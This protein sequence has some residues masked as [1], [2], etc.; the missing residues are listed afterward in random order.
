MHLG[1]DPGF[2][3]PEGHMGEH[4]GRLAVQAERAEPP[5]PREGEVAVARFLSKGGVG[6]HGLWPFPKGVASG[7]Q[8]ISCRPS[9]PVICAV[10]ICPSG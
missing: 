4:R 1:L 5:L 2:V 9:C 6:V 3:Q 10:T 8:T 7:A